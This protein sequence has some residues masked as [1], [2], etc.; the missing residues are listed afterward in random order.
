MVAKHIYHH[1][2]NIIPFEQHG[3]MARRSTVTNLA[4]L[5]DL[6]TKTMLTIKSRSIQLMLNNGAKN[7][8][9]WVSIVKNWLRNYLTNRQ[10]LV[11]TNSLNI[12]SP[13]VTFE[14]NKFIE[15]VEL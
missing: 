2:N 8:T 1:L 11:R 12:P 3:F 7:L 5:V 10:Q 6:M 9:V 14:L 4:N 13:V 15:N